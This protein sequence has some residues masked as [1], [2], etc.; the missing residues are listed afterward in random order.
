MQMKILIVFFICSITVNALDGKMEDGENSLRNKRQRFD[1]HR[2]G[3]FRGQNGGEFGRR[4]QNGG[5][6]AQITAAINAANA[7]KPQTN[8]NNNNIGT[9]PNGGNVNNN[10]V[11]QIQV[12]NVQVNK[13]GNRGGNR[14]R[15]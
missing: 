5:I 7:V 11:N 12:I 10:N 4:G 6:S 13:G 8:I 14:G 9:T 3:G 1:Q 2:H 15:F